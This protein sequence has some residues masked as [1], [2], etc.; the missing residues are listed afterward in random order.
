MRAQDQEPI[1]LF[2]SSKACA[3]AKELILAM[4]GV[5]CAQP[6]KEGT[7]L[8]LPNRSGPDPLLALP[9]SSVGDS[10]TPQARLCALPGRDPH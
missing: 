8:L 3:I 4:G 1:E 6:P 9:C 5:P 7:T 10:P 2:L